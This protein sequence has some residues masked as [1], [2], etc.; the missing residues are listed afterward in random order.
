MSFLYELRHLSPFAWEFMVIATE[1]D[2]GLPESEERMHFAIE[3][4]PKVH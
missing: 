3:I 4:Y 2:R 1:L